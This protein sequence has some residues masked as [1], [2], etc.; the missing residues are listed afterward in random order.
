MA[1]EANVVVGADRVVFSYPHSET[2]DDNPPRAQENVLR[3]IAHYS[4]KKYNSF[5]RFFYRNKQ[6]KSRASVFMPMKI[7][8]VLPAVDL[9]PHRSS[10]DL[11][12]V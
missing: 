12:F 5:V 4:K 3:D 10:R 9:Y 8:G 2:S 11:R 6:V 1:D 7:H